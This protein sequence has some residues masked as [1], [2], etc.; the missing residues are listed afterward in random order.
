MK[1]LNILLN[2]TLIF[3]FILFIT[4]ASLSTSV[5]RIV[6]LNENYCFYLNDNEFSNRVS[7]TSKYGY[8]VHSYPG[9]E[10]LVKFPLNHPEN[11]TDL[12]DTISG[13]FLTGGTFTSDWGWLTCQYGNGIL[14]KIDIITGEM[15]CIGGGGVS[16]YDIA[17]DDITWTLYGVSNNKFY[18][19][20]PETGEQTYLDSVENLYY[21]T[22]ITFDNN[23]NCYAVD[24]LTEIMYIIDVS[25]F[26]ATP[27]DSRYLNSLSISHLEFDKDNNQL[28][29]SDGQI[30][31]IYNLDTELVTFIGFIGFDNAFTIPYEYYWNPPVTTITFDPPEPDGEKGWYTSDVTVTL[32]ATDDITGVNDT[33]YRINEEEWIIYEEPF[34]LIENGKNILIEYYSIDFA[35][36]KEKTKTIT[37]DI[38][39]TAPELIVEWEVKKESWSK[40]IVTFFINTTDDTSY[41]E[42]LEY[43]INNELLE[44][45]FYPN[46][47]IIFGIYI[48]IDKS[49][50]FKFIAFNIAGKY[51][52]VEV[53]S[54]E[55]KNLAHCINIFSNSLN[56]I[57]VNHFIERF[58]NLKYPLNSLIRYFS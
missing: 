28:Y 9:P 54:S 56:N 23:G 36:N 38:D 45:I 17:W 31:Y 46:S 7:Y 18:E 8:G 25:T 1:K 13:D 37:I 47:T 12:G 58:P 55:I 4:I 10:E 50:R 33:Y 41:V 34:V 5:G 52:T 30:L 22:Q 48:P 14:Y 11:V 44:T 3:G 35:G 51:I 26:E 6:K 2:K 15:E 24:F 42:R 57:F 39:K 27:I 21:I 43:Y 40:W 16:L 19:I 20:N 29:M 49:F 32:N 53:D